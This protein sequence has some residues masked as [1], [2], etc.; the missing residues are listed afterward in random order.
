MDFFY[1]THCHLR[2]GPHT[3]RV[4]KGIR[5][6]QPTNIFSNR[7]AKINNIGNMQACEENNK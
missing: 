3:T 4:T 1:S 2:F 6:I 5:K 7:D